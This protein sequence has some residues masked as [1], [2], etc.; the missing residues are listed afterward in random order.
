MEAHIA[1][2][3]LAA[4]LVNPRLRADGVSYAKSVMLRNPTR[5]QLDVD[6]VLARPTDGD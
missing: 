3:T 4:R 1:L 2:S 5:I 6:T